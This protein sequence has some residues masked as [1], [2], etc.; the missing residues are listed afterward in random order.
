MPSGKLEALG[1]QP[2][3]KITNNLSFFGNSFAF[4]KHFY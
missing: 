3:S 4:E 2:D 1:F